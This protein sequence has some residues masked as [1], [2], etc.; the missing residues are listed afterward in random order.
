M[1]LN[2]VTSLFIGLALTGCATTNTSTVAVT[3]QKPS[4]TLSQEETWNLMTGKWY[5]SQPTKDGGKKQEIMERSPQGTYKITFRVFDKDGK[6]KEQAEAGHWGVSGPV[7][8]TIFRGWI[9]GDQLSPSNPADPYNYDAYK[10]IELNTDVFEYENY[11][12]GNRY[13]IKR[14]PNDFQFPN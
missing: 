11:S 7:Y 5:G 10:I 2:I 13:V 8:F 4:L 14:V 1:R 6:Y 3:S 9:E 12:S